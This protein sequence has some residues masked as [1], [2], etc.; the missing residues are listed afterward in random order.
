MISDDAGVRKR[1][2]VVC[3]AGGELVS[4]AAKEEDSVYALYYDFHEPLNKIAGHR[5]LAVNRGERR[6]S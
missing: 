6:N 5:I 4:K 2:R 1:L 3:M